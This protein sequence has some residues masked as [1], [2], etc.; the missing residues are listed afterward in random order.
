MNL[1]TFDPIEFRALQM[2]V[3]VIAGTLRARDPGFR[4]AFDSAVQNIGTTPLGFPG[5]TAAESDH[6]TAEFQEAW[7]QLSL[8]VLL[9]AS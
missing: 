4:I 7:R 2:M 5:V 3:V 6:Y 1:E 9:P 8:L